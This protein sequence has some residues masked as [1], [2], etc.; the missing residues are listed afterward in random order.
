MNIELS[1]SECNVL[2]DA[3]RF[4]YRE[5]REFLKINPDSKLDKEAVEIIPKLIKKLDEE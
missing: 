1:S 5:S 3:L 2:K 4:A